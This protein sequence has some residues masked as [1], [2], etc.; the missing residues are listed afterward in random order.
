MGGVCVCLPI[1][2]SRDDPPSRLV[3]L[4]TLGFVLGSALVSLPVLCVIDGVVRG[5]REELNVTRDDLVAC[6]M[7]LNITTMAHDYC[8]KK[9]HDPVFILPELPVD[10][11]RHE[12]R[13]LEDVDRMFRQFACV[14]I[15][16]HIRTLTTMA[17]MLFQVPF[18]PPS[19]LYT[20]G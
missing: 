11:H 14:G 18:D 12:T 4:F 2:M 5:L 15:T 16:V 19:I 3:L 7:E 8:V 6:R 10:T 1:P 17:A 13:I 20:C 9:Q